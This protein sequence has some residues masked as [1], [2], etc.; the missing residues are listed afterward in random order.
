MSETQKFELLGVRTWH[1]GHPINTL[2]TVPEP[3]TRPGHICQVIVDYRDLG[4]THWG[5]TVCFAGRWEINREGLKGDF[6]PIVS[7]VVP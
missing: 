4:S 7:A 5:K 2:G 1:P 6:G 3:S